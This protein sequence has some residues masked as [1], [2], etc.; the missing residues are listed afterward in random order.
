MT[1]PFS[2]VIQHISLTEGYVK[3][4]SVPLSRSAMVVTFIENL[5]W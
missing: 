5:H 2:R 3:Q 1:D 4:S